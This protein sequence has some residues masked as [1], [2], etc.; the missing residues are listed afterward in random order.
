MLA[1]QR[2]V[3]LYLTWKFCCAA[4]PQVSCELA[5]LGVWGGGVGGGERREE[6]KEKSCV[7]LPT[8]IPPR[9]G[10]FTINVY[11]FFF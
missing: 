1:M 3:Q 7:S 11:L 4:A 2:F 10:S 8:S 6:E 5:R 9:L